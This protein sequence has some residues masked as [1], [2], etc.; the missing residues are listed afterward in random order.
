MLLPSSSEEYKWIQRGQG[1]F[2]W[3]LTISAPMFTIFRWGDGV[4]ISEIAARYCHFTVHANGTLYHFYL[5]LWLLVVARRATGVFDGFS[6]DW[7][8]NDRA[9]YVD[10]VLFLMMY[11][12]WLNTAQT[13][14]QDLTLV[15]KLTLML[16][17][18]LHSHIQIFV[19]RIS[20]Y[21]ISL[22]E[23]EAE[24]LFVSISNHTF[25]SRVV[26]K[27]KINTS[28]VH[29]AGLFPTHT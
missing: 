23:A 3:E 4:P 19:T 2:W 22:K 28:S 12:P 1:S 21:P 24:L 29:E 5:T 7:H 27:P 18:Q 8:E 6:K 10:L 14:F 9:Y 20:Q 16:L 15:S 25:T 17:P 11:C 13:L 26:P